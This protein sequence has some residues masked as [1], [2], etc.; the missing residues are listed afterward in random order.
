MRGEYRLEQSPFGSYF[1]C[2]G[3]RSG[4]MRYVLSPGCLR[5]ESL[6]MLPFDGPIT[7]CV[8]ERSRALRY[9]AIAGQCNP[10][11]ELA[12]SITDPVP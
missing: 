10:R 9:A 11:G 5:G 7:I 12:Y 1:F 8:G 6:L 2:V 4:N 3:D